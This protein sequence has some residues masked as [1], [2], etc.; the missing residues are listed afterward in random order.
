[1]LSGL[2]LVAEHQAR[3]MNGEAGNTDQHTELL[4]G[5]QGYSFYLLDKQVWGRGHLEGIHYLAILII[6]IY[7]LEFLL[8]SIIIMG[9]YHYQLFAATDS[10]TLILVKL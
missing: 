2:P 8:S 7:Y 10:N 1:M 4:F 3:L 6:T 9:S 5:F